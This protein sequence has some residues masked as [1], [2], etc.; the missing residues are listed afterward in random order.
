MEQTI[1]SQLVNNTVNLIIV[2][3]GV[4]TAHKFVVLPEDE[5]EKKIFNAVLDGFVQELK[6]V[7]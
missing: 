2:K 1:E 4:K 3:D 6:S 7:V 5:S